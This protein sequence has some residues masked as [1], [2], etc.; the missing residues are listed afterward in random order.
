MAGAQEWVFMLLSEVSLFCMLM[1]DW[2]T[3]KTITKH[4]RVLTSL[5]KKFFEKNC[6]NSSASDNFH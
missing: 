2:L 6:G 5:R 3:S 1:I 4:G